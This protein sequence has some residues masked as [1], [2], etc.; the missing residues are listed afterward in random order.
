[1]TAQSRTVL[2]VSAL[3]VLA[4]LTLLWTERSTTSTPVPNEHEQ[5]APVGFHGTPP[6]SPWPSGPEVPPACVGAT[7]TETGAAPPPRLY[8]APTYVSSPRPRAERR[9]RE[10]N[11]STA[12]AD[13]REAALM[14]GASTERV[15]L[16]DRQ[17]PG[18]TQAFV[19][20]DFDNDG[21]VDIFATRRSGANRLYLNR[22]K[23]A[24]QDVTLTFLLHFGYSSSDART[25][26]ADGDG[27]LDLLVINTAAPPQLF[28][29]D[30]EAKFLAVS[31]GL[32]S[33]PRANALLP[34][35][36]DADQ[37]IDLAVDTGSQWLIVRNDDARFREVLQRVRR[38]DVANTLDLDGDGVDE[39]VL[40]DR[41]QLSVVTPRGETTFDVDEFAADGVR[42]LLVIATGDER[43]LLVLTRRRLL[44]VSLADYPKFDLGKR[45]VER[46]RGKK[47]QFS[48]VLAGDLN[49]DQIAEVVLLQSSTA[50]ILDGSGSFA[51]TLT[52]L[53]AATCALADIDGDRDLDLIVAE[54]GGDRILVNAG[55]GPAEQ[56]RR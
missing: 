12:E 42:D 48:Q 2:G 33:L 43:S 6:S 37:A 3:V 28:L 11:A 27:D 21:D 32:D 24:F 1:M 52:I 25:F 14:F 47:A 22:G 44:S 38:A 9:R 4:L 50:T 55:T 46:H 10:T 20:A 35:R 8:L 17:A 16:A 34:L 19:T 5:L 56:R 40:A 30:G 51:R 54:P 29:N 39:L 15:L 7:E 13:E 18:I 31:D 41:R 45:L 36:W 53:P 26:D 49:G 23:G